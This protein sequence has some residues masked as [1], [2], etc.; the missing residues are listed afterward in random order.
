MNEWIHLIFVVLYRF[1][2]MGVNVGKWLKVKKYYPQPEETTCSCWPYYYV[3]EWL[4]AG[5]YPQTKK[6]LILIKQTEPIENII[7]VF[8]KNVYM[9][10]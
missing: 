1:S 8:N 7:I 10:A 4:F 3:R 5:Y 9:L 2:C 6:V